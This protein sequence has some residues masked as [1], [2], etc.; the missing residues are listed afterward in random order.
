VMADVVP[1]INPGGV[2]LSRALGALPKMDSLQVLGLQ[3]RY[4]DWSKPDQQGNYPVFDGDGRMMGMYSGSDIVL[5]AMGTDLGRFN[6]QGEVTQFLLKNRDQMRDQRR[7]WIASVLSNN[8]A[9]AGKIKSNYER[10]FGMPLTVTQQQMRQA[11]DVREGSIASR[12]MSSMDKDLQQQYK[13]LL[14]QSVPDALT[15]NS[16]PVEQGAMYVWNKLPKR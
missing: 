6:N 15:K 2:A 13:D 16:F 5:R 9:Q 4:A 1:M 12:T 7:Q 10:Q 3:K 14:G 8:M 11:I